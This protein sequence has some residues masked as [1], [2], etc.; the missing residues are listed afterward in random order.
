MPQTSQTVSCHD[1]SKLHNLCCSP[2]KRVS[3]S[4]AIQSVAP[5]QGRSPRLPITCASKTIYLFLPLSESKTASPGMNISYQFDSADADAILL[6]T[7]I[8]HSTEF[9]VHKCILAAASPFFYDMFTLP[10]EVENPAK[11]QPVISVAE[12]SHDLDI[13]LRCIYPVPAPT[14]HSLDELSAA[15]GVALKYDFEI[16]TSVLRNLLVSPQFLQS[17][18]VR[19]YAIACRYELEAEAKIASQRT[20]NTSILDKPPC[21]ELRYI[22]A[23]DYHRLL[24]L[25]RRRSKAATDLLN[26]TPSLEC[27]NCN[28]S[29]FT[30]RQAP[31]WWHEFTHAAQEELS[32]RPTTDTIFGMEFL[33][34]M[35]R[36]SG[37]ARCPES[38]LNSWKVL[39][40]LK[41]AIDALPSTVTFGENPLDDNVDIP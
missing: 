21:K 4:D 3:N 14:I 17:S 25:H 37:C 38:V 1:V 22:S 30:V 7:E 10:Q 5:L 32:L 31:K 15:L 40:S 18:P 24:T 26:A 29:A 23:Y 11:Q 34:R 35:A 33:F 8:D 2:F 27:T 28:S 6:T 16:A 36:A 39:E 13:V 12:T 19:V 9:H 20:L 41:A